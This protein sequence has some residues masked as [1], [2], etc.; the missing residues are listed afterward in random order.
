MLEL[1]IDKSKK[2]SKTI[3]KYFGH[4]TSKEFQCE[5]KSCYVEVLAS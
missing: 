3:L 5:K 2:K 1:I 4:T